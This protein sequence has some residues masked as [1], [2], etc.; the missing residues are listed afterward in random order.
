MTLRLRLAASVVF[1]TFFAVLG[2]VASAQTPAG[3]ETSAASVASTASRAH[4]GRSQV[5]AAPPNG[6]RYIRTGRKPDAGPSC[7][8]SSSRFSAG[9]RGPERARAFRRHMEFEGPATSPNRA[10]DFDVARLVSA[11]TRMRRRATTIPSTRWGAD[12]RW[13]WTARSSRLRRATSIRRHDRGGVPWRE[14]R[15]AP[16][17]L[18]GQDAIRGQEDPVTPIGPR[19]S[20]MSSNAQRE[21][22]RLPRLYG[23][24]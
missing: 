21:Q 7:G 11:P 16:V 5:V 9:R 18:S 15:C 23:R 22:L 17:R 20:R 3:R 10:L 13:G 8:S 12:R 4:A 19:T 24:I 14:W 1:A 2:L 6:P